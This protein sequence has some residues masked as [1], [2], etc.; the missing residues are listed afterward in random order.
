MCANLRSVIVRSDV[1]R[2]TF[3]SMILGEKKKTQ[4]TSNRCSGRPGSYQRPPIDNSGP[5]AVHLRLLRLSDLFHDLDSTPDEEGSGHYLHFTLPGVWRLRLG[6]I[7]YQPFGHCT[8]VCSYS[9]GNIQHHR[10][11]PRNYFTNCYRSAF[12]ITAYSSPEFE[13][14][15]W[16]HAKCR[17][18]I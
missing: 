3:P 1:C 7:L 6:R 16:G 8:P 11:N 12:P 14:L 13:D 17:K 9:D 5:E 15:K 10:D 2:E 4:V 18:I